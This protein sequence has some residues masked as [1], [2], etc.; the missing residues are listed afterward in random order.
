M[1]V[2]PRFTSAPV[3]FSLHVHF[4]VLFQ[5]PNDY[6]MTTSEN[7]KAVIRLPEEEAKTVTF[8]EEDIIGNDPAKRKVRIKVQ[9]AG[10]KHPTLFSISPAETVDVLLQGFCKKSGLNPAS[11]IFQFDGMTMERNKTLEEYEI[12]DDD[13]IIDA[14]VKQ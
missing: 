3:F 13:Y 1:F 2:L 4:V 7:I 14:T 9:Q 10:V 8:G 12:D 5:T 6:Y 11:V